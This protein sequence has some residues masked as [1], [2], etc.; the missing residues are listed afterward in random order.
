M[1]GCGRARFPYRQFI[2]ASHRTPVRYR[3]QPSLFLCRTRHMSTASPIHPV[4][5]SQQRSE[6]ALDKPHADTDL[7]KNGG[8]QHVKEKKPKEQPGSAYPLEVRRSNSSPYPSH[9]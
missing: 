7:T 3:P 9:A 4:E 1:L 8:A 2:A 5:T 6:T